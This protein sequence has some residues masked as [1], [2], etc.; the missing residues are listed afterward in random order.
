MKRYLTAYSREVLTIRDRKTGFE[1]RVT[2]VDKDTAEVVQDAVKS[3]NYYL[4]NYKN[5]KLQVSS[6]K[7][8]PYNLI[9]TKHKQ[10]WGEFPPNNMRWESEI[11][12]EK[13]KELNDKLNQLLNLQ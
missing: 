10:Y 9:H 13:E 11:V 4:N 12:A 3:T 8:L 1:K 6:I 2:H 7:E 5:G